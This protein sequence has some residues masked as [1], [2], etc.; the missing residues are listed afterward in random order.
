MNYYRILKSELMKMASQMMGETI[1]VIS[2]KPL[3]P[4]EAIGKPDRTD[5]PLLKGKEVMVEAVFRESRAHAFTDM[6]GNFHGS[7]QNLIDLDLRNN[8]ERAVFIAG[9][10]A[11]MRN[12][13][14]IANTVHCKDSEP[15][16]CAEQLPA[17]VTTH[18]GNPKIAFVGYQPAMLETLSR[19]F[20]LRVIDLDK[21]NI[22]AN[23]FGLVIEGPENTEDMLS[24]GDIIWATGSTCVN[25]T[26]VSFL[27]KKPVVF[28]GVTVAGPAMLHGYQR[29]C[30]CSG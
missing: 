21:D 16:R 18:F 29:F 10:N 6:P 28:Y 11:V 25:G 24:W 26:I 3:S 8:F 9:F 2:A 20:D 1:K 7:L 17:F 4:E 22:G 23:R 27:E 12:F 15:K 13:G 5:F 14:R 19:S 30:P